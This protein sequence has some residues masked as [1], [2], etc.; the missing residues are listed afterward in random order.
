MIAQWLFSVGLIGSLGV[1]ALSAE[2][3]AD[4]EIWSKVALGILTTSTLLG[5]F[6]LWVFG[7]K[8]YFRISIALGRHQGLPLLRDPPR[9]HLPGTARLHDD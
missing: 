6:M 5:A 8:F 2:M 9:P 7:W 4:S 3:Q 1:G